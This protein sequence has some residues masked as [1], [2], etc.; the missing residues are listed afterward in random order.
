MLQP[1]T[2]M[3]S[4]E[5]SRELVKPIIISIIISCV[6]YLYMDACGMVSLPTGPVGDMNN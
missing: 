1:K 6:P 3:Q 2:V 4:I 5:S